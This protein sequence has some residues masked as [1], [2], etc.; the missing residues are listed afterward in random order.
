LQ[1]FDKALHALPKG[2]EGD[3]EPWIEYHDG[4]AG[5]HAS[6]VPIMVADGRC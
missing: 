1:A 3:V 2:K 4:K 6:G 5:I